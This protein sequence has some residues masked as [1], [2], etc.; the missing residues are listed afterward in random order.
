M[1][2]ERFVQRSSAQT[3]QLLGLP[4]RGI[5]AP[6]KFADIAILDARSYAERATYDRPDLPSTGVRYV[7]V[8]GRIA[9]DKGQLSGTLAGRP[10][11]KPRQA[12]WNCPA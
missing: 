9:V 3:A 12:N 10:L 2:P 4:D 5:L 6:G 7:L 8:N 1:S 11:P